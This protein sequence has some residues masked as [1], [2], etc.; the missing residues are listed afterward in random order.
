LERGVN[1]YPHRETVLALAEAL[2]LAG[3]DRA[4]LFDA[5]HRRRGNAPLSSA[6]ALLAYPTPGKQESASPAPVVN[7]TRISSAPAPPATGAPEARS[8][9]SATPGAAG[10]GQDQSSSQPG[11]VHIFLIADVRGYTHFTYEH[12]DEVAAQLAMRFAA[13]ARAVVAA[14]AGQVVEL[15]GD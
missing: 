7:Q 2:Q 8:D 1:H 13:V 9:V 15:R 3:A 5:A 11:A 12:G 6:A 10:T 14:H 4:R